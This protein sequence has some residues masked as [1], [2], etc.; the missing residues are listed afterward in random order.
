MAGVTG[1]GSPDQLIPQEAGVAQPPAPMAESE[2]NFDYDA[3][4]QEQLSAESGLPQQDDDFDYDKWA[5]AQVA[6]ESEDLDIDDEH[7]NLLTQIQEFPARLEASFAGNKKEEKIVLE[8]RYGAENV[9]KQ[10]DDFL[11]RKGDK[12]KKFDSDSFE[13]L[14]DIIADGG[15]GIVEQ[16]GTEFG[17]AT[18]VAAA[19]LMAPATAGGSVLA[20]PA[21][22][23]ASRMAGGAFGVSLADSIAENLYNIP[24]DPERSKTNEAITGA[25]VNA[26]FGK[27]GDFVGSYFAKKGAE[28]ATRLMNESIDKSLEADIAVLREA[29]DVLSDANLLTPIKTVFGETTYLAENAIKDGA[30]DITFRAKVY[31][32]NPEVIRAKGELGMGVQKV[33]TGINDKIAAVSNKF[34]GKDILNKVNNIEVAEAEMLVGFR[35]DF[36]DAAGDRLQPMSKT[37]EALKT[38][39]DSIGYTPGAKDAPKDAA[40]RLLNK[41]F[42]KI[43]NDL[44]NNNGSLSA[45]DLAENYKIINKISKDMG[46][47]D[48]N[49]SDRTLQEN[50]IVKLWT[51]VRDDYSIAIKSNVGEKVLPTNIQGLYKTKTYGQTLDRFSEIKNAKL[52]LKNLLIDSNSGEANITA[53]ALAHHLFSNKKTTLKDIDAAKLLFKEDP[54]AWNGI[55]RIELDNLL[56]KSYNAKK[57]YFDGT[58]FV[59]SVLSLPNDVALELAGGQ[60]GLNILE[61]AQTYSNR[62][63]NYTLENLSKSNEAKGILSK[64]LSFTGNFIQSKGL[65]MWDLISATGRNRS[66]AKYLSAEGRDEMLKLAPVDAR[67]NMAKAIDYIVDRARESDG[68]SARAAKFIAPRATQMEIRKDSRK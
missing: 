23:G 27:V 4:A 52:D 47:W 67:S 65:A 40:S 24:R 12:W 51:G 43:S 66:V 31:A 62:L 61:A 3:W 50:A 1:M 19:G 17:T 42:E 48:K 2:D 58:K 7:P 39:E 57:E 8:R 36:V 63:Q 16:A 21:V 41:Q 37:Q 6:A 35:D 29:S 45:S 56:K 32:D 38:I 25:V 20:A 55:R 44:F 64:T 14:N 59:Q 11:I 18:G 46:V 15:R 60:K 33:I 28:K 53:E 68:K 54:D 34:S 22:V 49:F 30:P 13:V 26:T 5:E 9:K 10:G